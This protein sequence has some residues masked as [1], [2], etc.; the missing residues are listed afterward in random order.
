MRGCVR[1]AGHLLAVLVLL[2]A[3]W[4]ILEAADRVI[5]LADGLYSA[6]SYEEAITEY[7][8]FVFFHPSEELAWHA[9]QRMGLCYRDEGRWDEAASSFR[10]AAQEAPDAA[11]R[12]NSELAEVGV[13]LASGNFGDAELRL[14]MARSFEDPALLAGRDAVYLC[15]VYTL[16]ARW[17][18]AERELE[19]PLPAILPSAVADART[20][21]GKARARGS[22]SR[23]TARVLSTFLPGAGQAYA[24][25]WGDAVNAFAVNVLSA[26][27]VVLAAIAGD[28]V[29]AV[30]VFSYFFERYYT[31]NIEKAGKLAA[32]RGER[33]S[34]EAAGRLIPLLLTAPDGSPAEDA[35]ASDAASAVPVPHG[36]IGQTAR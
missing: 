7:E 34:K 15:V 17:E 23:A 25:D 5:A 13:L 3:P 35:G 10:E 4:G 9:R 19:R 20:L 6:G 16:T 14:L 33:I 11:R 27:L 32:L 31:A 22:P 24:G 18:M 26:A 1:R 28:Y 12:I 8:R 30:L 36:Q 29:E 2:L 21:V